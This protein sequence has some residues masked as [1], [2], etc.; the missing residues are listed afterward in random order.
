MQGQGQGQG[1]DSQGPGQG[2]G[3]KFGS[4]W[5]RRG[6]VVYK[7]DTELKPQ[8]PKLYTHRTYSLNNKL[9][10]HKLNK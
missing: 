2:Q 10:D 7:D 1:L 6:L 3:L 9:A 8:V 4:F 5:T